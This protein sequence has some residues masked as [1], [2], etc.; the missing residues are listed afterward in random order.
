MNYYSKPVSFLF[1]S[2]TE[3]N[4]KEPKIEI[5]WSSI[6]EEKVQIGSTDNTSVKE[7]LQEQVLMDGSFPKNNVAEVKDTDNINVENNETSEGIQSVENSVEVEKNSDNCGEVEEG[8]NKDN[9]SVGDDIKEESSN[10]VCGS[11]SHDTTEYMGKLDTSVETK[12]CAVLSSSKLD[13]TS[14]SSS[15]SDVHVPDNASTIK[16]A[17]DSSVDNRYGTKTKFLL[18]VRLRNNL[19]RPLQGGQSLKGNFDKV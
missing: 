7:I 5:Q 10:S 16:S 6:L 15:M 2:N 9:S 13:T 17:P 12:D 18:R 8:S 19:K 3:P 1:Y 4:S 14:E 11:T